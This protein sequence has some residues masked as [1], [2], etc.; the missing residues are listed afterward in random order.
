MSLLVANCPRCG[1]GR[2]TFD[3]T[4]ANTAGRRYSWQPRYEVFSVCRACHTASIF[5]ISVSQLKRKDAKG[6][7]AFGKPEDIVRYEHG[8]NE[9][10]EV[11]RFISLRDQVFLRPP[12]HLPEPIIAGFN[13]AAACLSIGCNNAAATMFRLCIDLAT[14]PL[15]PDP[16]DETKPQ[17]NAKVRRDLGLR[18]N[19]LFENS[20]IQPSL[21]ELAK[22][23]RED[24]NDGAH[25][26]NLTTEDAEEVAE[27]TVVLLERLFT[28]P[29][30]L[31][32]AEKRRIERR[33]PKADEQA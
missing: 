5:I 17:P 3:V 24:A 18:L 26:G 29:K 11:E 4:A 6:E 33:K 20:L 23:I 15:L 25:V 28:E 31:E 14:R 2:V 19:W 32:L 9:L 13:E 30:Q 27:F 21:R 7:N 16:A 8:L 22:C 10:F 1:T 12:Q